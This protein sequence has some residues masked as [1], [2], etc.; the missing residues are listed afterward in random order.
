MNLK[1]KRF[2]TRAYNLLL[3][4]SIFGW[5]SGTFFIL[6]A[7]EYV[8]YEELGILLAVQFTV[9]II[10]DYPT[11]TVGDWIGQK[12]VYAS[13]LLFFSTGFFIFA[14][15]K[16]FD[17]HLIAFILLGIANAQN[18]GA[19]RAWYDNN[20][21]LYFPEDEE[22][23]LYALIAGKARSLFLVCQGAATII[24]GFL[25]II[26]GRAT[27]FFLVSITDGLLIIIF[28]IYMQDNPIIQRVKPKIGEYFHLLGEGISFSFKHRYFRVILLGTLITNVAV[29]IWANF[30]LFPF[31]ESYAKTDSSIGLFRAIL[32][33]ESAFFAWI[34]ASIA[35]RVTKKSVSTIYTILS[36]TVLPLWYFLLIGV[37]LFVPPSETFQ[38][39]PLV[40]LVI[41]WVV[42]HFG[43]PLVS[44]LLQRIYLDIIPDNNRTSI[45]SLIPALTSLI[46][47]PVMIIGGIIV[48]HTSFVIVTSIIM[49]L[50]IIG[51]II[52]G[53]AVYFY[54]KEKSTAFFSKYSIVVDA[55]LGRFLL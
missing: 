30:L 14:L 11:G 24:G 55:E 15:A 26:I 20:Y 54:G 46:N 9:Q 23:N 22:R 44:L 52:S 33:I 37:Y 39:L 28:L 13:A 53:L 6:K 48:E 8:S 3:I 18:S 5:M 35:A 31:Y 16:S 40:L 38:I 42:S 49:S 2:V 4:D 34:A 25:V 51:G 29:T 27:M 17:L 1:G 7:L 12:Y 21:K 43:Y 41:V 10:I 50:C 19:W 32:F 45:Y 47:I 36:S